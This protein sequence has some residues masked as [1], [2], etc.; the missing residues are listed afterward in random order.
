VALLN[1]AT[2]DTLREIPLTSGR[3]RFGH[4]GGFG[5]VDPVLSA[6][7]RTL[8][9]ALPGGGVGVVNTETGITN[10][11][12]AAGKELGLL[13]L[14]PD[15]RRLVTA[16]RDEM[17]RWWD[18]RAGTNTL[19]SIETVRAV[20]SPD[21]RWVAT[22]HPEGAIHVWSAE[23]RAPQAT[24]AG[25]E[26]LTGWADLVFSPDGRKLAVAYADHTI[27]LWD[28]ERGKWQGRFT[29]HKQPVRSL[30]FSADSRTLASAGADSTLRL[31]NVATQQELL[32]ERRLG[33]NWRDLRFSPDGQLLV[34]GGGPESEGLRYFRAPVVSAAELASRHAAAQAR[35]Q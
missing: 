20:F 25:E 14:S 6:D 16:G 1:L 31:W 8:V 5:L 10:L 32:V 21:G 22:V 15:G 17:P 4:G 27:G 2:G 34:G 30:A 29:G 11:W 26:F 9:H 7:L 28:A 13:A 12:P 19:W 35:V 18:L 33:A 24:L 23:D 3:P